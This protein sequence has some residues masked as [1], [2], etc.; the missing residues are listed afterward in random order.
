MPSPAIWP[1]KNRDEV[2]IAGI[3]FTALV[4]GRFDSLKS[5]E[6]ITA[7]TCLGCGFLL[8]MVMQGIELTC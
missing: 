3:F 8:S 2:E 7:A 4:M 1:R 5:Y 6:I